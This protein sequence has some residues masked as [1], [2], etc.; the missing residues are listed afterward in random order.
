LES[1]REALWG[2]DAPAFDDQQQLF[3]AIKAISDL[4]RAEP[5]LRYGRLYFRQVSGNGRDFG[6]STGAGGILAYSRILSDRELLVVA[7]T[8]HD[9]AFAGHVLVDLDLNRRQEQLQIAYSSHGSVGR[10]PID[11]V[12]KASFWE[13]GLFSGRGIAA[14]PV[15]LEPM[16]LQII[17]PVA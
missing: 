12:A 14:V 1:V 9:Q 5:A 7:N 4:R 2:K 8:N 13:S 10:L 3:E 6:Y 17:S 15:A 11:V 16:E